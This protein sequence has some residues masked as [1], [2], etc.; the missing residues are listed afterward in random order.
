[1]WADIDTNGKN[2]RKEVRLNDRREHLNELSASASPL[3]LLHI[4]SVLGISRG[5]LCDATPMLPVSVCVSH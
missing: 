1:M 4:P 5:A 2:E 3:I